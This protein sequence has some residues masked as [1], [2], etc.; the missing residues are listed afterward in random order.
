LLFVTLQYKGRETH[1]ENPSA[2][3]VTTYVSP[4]LIDPIPKFST[5]R[6][7]HLP[8]HLKNL[9]FVGCA[10]DRNYT[11][12]FTHEEML[13]VNSGETT[14]DG[15]IPTAHHPN[16]K[17][18]FLDGTI[19]QPINTPVPVQAAS[20]LAAMPDATSVKC[21]LAIIAN[22]E[23]WHHCLGHIGIPTIRKIAEHKLAKGMPVDLSQLPIKCKH[24]ILS[25]QTR[26]FVPK[27]RT[28][29]RSTRKLGVVYVA[30][31]TGMG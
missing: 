1:E 4:W 12:V 16:K 3:R 27:T 8:A 29:A 31:D 5:P 10:T 30:M 14:V 18:Y 22:L 25:K 26:T 15:I 20:A 7:T 23:V 17:L 21:A 19:V 24:C 11:A 28:H 2:S 9:M 6:S 13:I